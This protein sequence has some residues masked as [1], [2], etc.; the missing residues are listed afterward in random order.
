MFKL[1]YFNKWRKTNTSIYWTVV[2]D[3]FEETFYCPTTDI[4][5]SYIYSIKIYENKKLNIAF[6]IVLMINFE[7]YK[8]SNNYLLENILE[9]EPSYKKYVSDIN[10]YLIL[11]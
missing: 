7:M 3:D 9:Q 10:K 1:M 8:Y 11:I 5:S 4:T 2:D 6:N